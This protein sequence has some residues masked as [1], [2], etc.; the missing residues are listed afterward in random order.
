MLESDEWRTGQFVLFQTSSYDVRD[1]PDIVLSSQWMLAA[2][3]C[4]LFAI[5][6]AVACHAPLSMG[7]LRQEYWSGLPFPSPRG[8][9]DPGIN[10]GLL[11]HRQIL[12]HLSHQG[13][14]SFLL[15]DLKFPQWSLNKGGHAVCHRLPVN[16]GQIHKGEGAP[17]S[18]SLQTS[19]R[20]QSFERK[21]YCNQY[22]VI[23][24]Q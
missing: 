5:P 24:F 2:Q 7:S 18:L 1:S 8:L 19:R 12:Y 23:I 9:P 16:T 3:S 21:Q 13:T 20:L 11:H 14:Y 15:P 4:L 17:L 22:S 6:W 10:P